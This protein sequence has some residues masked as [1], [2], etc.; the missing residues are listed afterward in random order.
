M[1]ALTDAWQQALGAEQ[2][3]AFGYPLAGPRLDS[4][5]DLARTC[6]AA[7]EALRD[8]TASAIEKAGATPALPPAD[9]PSLYPVRDAGAAQR[10]AIR[11]EQ[12][13]AK[14]WR[15]L[16]A[17]AAQGSGTDAVAARTAAQAALTA[18]AV[19]AT[20]WRL[21]VDPARATVAFPGI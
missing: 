8:Q 18:S 5:T 1:S 12:D 21:L 4:G 6:Q 10:L 14:A 11:L 19:R 7:H 20:Q 15:Y 16:Y 2:Q 17:V 9:F 13:A 3:A